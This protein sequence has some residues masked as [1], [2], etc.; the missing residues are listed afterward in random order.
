MEKVRDLANTY[1][2]REGRESRDPLS[3][4]KFEKVNVITS[5]NKLLFSEAAPLVDLFWAEDAG[6]RTTGVAKL[7]FTQTLVSNCIPSS[8]KNLSWVSFCPIHLHL[9]AKKWA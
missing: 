9:S 1:P 6:K 3:D 2:W 4:S 7:A 5:T 8:G